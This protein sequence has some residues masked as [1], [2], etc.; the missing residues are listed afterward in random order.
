MVNEKNETVCSQFQTRLQHM[1]QKIQQAETSMVAFQKTNILS[2][3]EKARSALLWLTEEKERFF[4]EYQE[5]AID[6]FWEWV[7]D[8]NFFRKEIEVSVDT[9]GLLEVTE[10]GRD[11]VQLFGKG[12]KP[13]LSL[14]KTANVYGIYLNNRDR[15]LPN[16]QMANGLIS[17]H[18]HTRKR[19]IIYAPVLIEAGDIRE[20]QK[21]FTPKLLRVEKYCIENNVTCH[22]IPPLSIREVEKFI[23]ESGV[24]FSA[25]YLRSVSEFLSVDLSFLTQPFSSL[26]E[27]PVINVYGEGSFEKAFPL[28]RN[29]RAIR[30]HSD[31][32]Y[33]QIKQLIRDYKI[34]RDVRLEKVLL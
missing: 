23:V 9:D 15:C 30:V 32:M 5:Q 8:D 25:P 14:I 16:L 10:V 20:G 33:S 19:R 27:A 4:K 6:L 18:E 7:D 31:T 29:C 3:Y 1:S 34:N 11:G 26:T 2:E 13:F 24:Q 28:L 22:R 17:T 21:L 12:N